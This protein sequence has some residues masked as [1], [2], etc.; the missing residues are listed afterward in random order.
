M[1]KWAIATISL[2]S[3]ASLAAL[4]IFMPDAQEH[5]NTDTTPAAS[6]VAP[7]TSYPVTEPSIDSTE[8]KP[9]DALTVTFIGPDERVLFVTEVGPG[10]AALPPGNPT[11]PQGYIFSHWDRDLSCV[12]DDLLV[13]AVCQKIDTQDNVLALSGGYLRVGDEVTIPVLLCGNVL[14]CAFDIR[15]HYDCSMLEFVEFRNK[16]G[17][18]DG[19]CN[20]QTGE[21]YMNYASMEN[22]EGEVYLAELV[23]RAAGDPG[24]TQIDMDVVELIAYDSDYNFYEPSHTTIPGAVTIVEP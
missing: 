16:D 5:H 11:M 9:D 13:Y 7:Q 6:Q 21:I 17:A 12:T 4:G 10:T 18:V 24:E 15:I 14:L 22:T 1:K 19:N 2:V 20:A 3:V 23:F 8:Y